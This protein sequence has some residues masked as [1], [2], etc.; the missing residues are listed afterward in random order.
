[1]K[2]CNVTVNQASWGDSKKISAYYGSRLSA[3]LTDVSAKYEVTVYG[4]YA[5]GAT[6]N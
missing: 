2:F 6:L 1:M 5:R 3:T 4:P